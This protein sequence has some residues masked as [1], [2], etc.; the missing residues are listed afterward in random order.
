LNFC[1]TKGNVDERNANVFNVLRRN[2]FGKLYGDKGNISST[3]FE[4]LFNDGTHLVTG[5]RSNM[6][7]RLMSFRD[8]ILLRKQSVIKTV[9]DELKN[10]CH[11]EHS[12][13]RSTHNFLI[14]LLAC[15]TAYCFFPKKPSIQFDIEHSEQLDLFQ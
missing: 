5:I 10:I 14:N 15:L 4:T 7:N 11:L 1:L 3:L 9:N 12:R 2:L 6:R 8:R 13:H